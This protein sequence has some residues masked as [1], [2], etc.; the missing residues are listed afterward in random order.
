MEETGK[1]VVLNLNVK[2][3]IKKT[4]FWNEDY[5]FT[6]KRIEYDRAGIEG[7]R[8]LEELDKKIYSYDFESGIVGETAIFNDEELPPN[9]KKNEDKKTW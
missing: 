7:F 9:E 5:I 2:P 4:K 6:N 8:D 1:Q 3:E